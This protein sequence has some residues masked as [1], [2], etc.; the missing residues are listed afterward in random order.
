MGVEIAIQKELEKQKWA[1][2]I[3]ALLGNEI[4]EITYNFHS[5][6]KVGSRA[7]PFGYRGWTLVWQQKFKEWLESKQGPSNKQENAL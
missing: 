3:L 1:I 2:L 4:I 7:H 6:L 5:N